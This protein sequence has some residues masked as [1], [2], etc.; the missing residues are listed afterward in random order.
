LPNGIH[1]PH[2]FSLRELEWD[3]W[4]MDVRDGRVGAARTHLQH[5]K[6]KLILVAGDCIAVFC[7]YSLALRMTSLT[8]RHGELR[9]LGISALAALLGIWAIRSQGLLLARVCAMRVVEITRTARAML[10]LAGLMLLFDRVAKVDLYI[11]Y[12]ALACALSFVFI[13]IARSRFRSWLGHARERGRYPRTVAIIGTDYEA[14]RLIDLFNTHRDI[15]MTVEGV[16]GNPTEA[17]DHGLAHLWLGEVKDAESI[18][19]SIG[20]SGVVL[21]A[22]GLAA[23]RL[24]E[25]IRNLHAAGRH[26]HLT[27]G[28]AGIDA[29]RLRPLPLAH[30]P[31]FYVEAPSLAKSQ[32][33]AKRCFDVV[34]AGFGLLILSPLLLLIALFVKLQDHGPVFF[35][36]TRVGRDGRNFGVL[37]FRSMTVNAEHRLNELSGANERQGPLFKMVGDPRVT[38]V[39]RILRSAGLD[40]LPQL[41]NVLRGEMSLVGPRPA[42]PSE[43]AN[44]SAELRMREQVLPGITGLWQVEARDNPSFEAYRRLDL[45]YVENWSITLDL[46]IIVGT[47][48]MFV[49][50]LFHTLVPERK[51][52]TTDVVPERGPIVSP[53][54]KPPFEQVA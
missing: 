33:V 26:V 46:I 15:G 20:A 31:L 49:S 1:S 41:I 24:N 52:A 39:G 35:R 8:E 29:R 21:S 54:R 9:A 12:T 7:G 40:E 5:N 50:Q 19:D 53:E 28:I 34:L 6:L 17:S 25:L 42:L 32:L 2:W 30:E 3:A 36:Q 11:R 38:R 45:F 18:V 48:E 23:N 14:V 27:T 51:S 22:S 37:K 13:C 47:I 16:I 43:V 4:V 44:F 10:I